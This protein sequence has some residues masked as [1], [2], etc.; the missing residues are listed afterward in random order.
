MLAAADIYAEQLARERE[1]AAIS[2]VYNLANKYANDDKTM[3]GS[4][5]LRG[6]HYF[7]A[8]ETVRS[9]LQARQTDN[10]HGE[11]TA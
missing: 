4:E 2:R 7:D 10:R 11:T 1:D 8:L 6:Y 3:I 9:E 5:S